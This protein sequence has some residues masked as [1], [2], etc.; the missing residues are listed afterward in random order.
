MPID[1]NKESDVKISGIVKDL[2]NDKVLGLLKTYNYT[3][4]IMDGLTN[5]K[6]T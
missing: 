1:S 3:L 4:L 2:R 6:N 5:N